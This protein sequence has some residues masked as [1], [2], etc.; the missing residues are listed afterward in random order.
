M[1]GMQASKQALE[2]GPPT[3]DALTWGA[4]PLGL[5]ARDDL[6]RLK[7][8]AAEDRRVERKRL[9]RAEK[10]TRSESASDREHSS[11]GKMRGARRG[12]R[13]RPPQ[14]SRRRSCSHDHC[15]HSWKNAAQTSAM[16]V[17]LTTRTIRPSGTSPAPPSLFARLLLAL[18]KE[19]SPDASNHRA[20]YSPASPAARP[21]SGRCTRRRT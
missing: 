8:R 3:V 19:C 10:H 21:R 7:C 15:R 17:Q 14:Q 16:I 18:S 9:L 12:S 13:C 2:Q 4:H 11:R 20:S 1:S 5:A 6:D